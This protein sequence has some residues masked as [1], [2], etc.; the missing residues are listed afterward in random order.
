MTK[1]R[2]MTKFAERKVL[3][4]NANLDCNRPLNLQ[5]GSFHGRLGGQQV[6]IA[7][8][9]STNWQQIAIPRF[10]GDYIA[11][12]DLLKNGNFRCLRDIYSQPRA[13]T[14]F[15]DALQAVAL[16]S[17]ANQLGKQDLSVEARK[18]YGT[19]IIKVATKLRNGEDATD[20][21]IMGASYLLTLFEVMFGLHLL[22]GSK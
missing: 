13:S 2:D 7:H 15:D 4:K 8:S 3:A 9:I 14:H 6:G 20:D 19:A 10:F 18:L 16:M 1:F 21:T 17:L 5:T 12:S 22:R 11:P